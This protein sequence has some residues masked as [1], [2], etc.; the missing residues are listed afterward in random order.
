MGTANGELQNTLILF[1]TN[2]GTELRGSLL[3]LTRFLAVF[4]LYSPSVVLRSSEVL[5]NCRIIIHERTLYSG[6]AVIH[7]LVNAGLTLVC[8]ATLNESAWKDVQFAPE[9]ARNGELR[10]EFRGLITEWQKLYKVNSDY[11]VIIADMQTFLADL[12]LWL[13][14]V[15]LGIRSSPS[16]DRMKLEQ[17]V[18]DDLAEPIVPCV[19]DMFE[20]FEEIAARL[21]VEARPAHWAYMRRQLHPLVLCAPFAY[22]TFYKPLGFAGDYEM[23]NMIA[24]NGQEGGNLFAKL[25]NTWF[26]RQPP[27]VAHRN[28]IDYLEQKL[29]EETARVAG[30]G[31]EARMYSVACGPAQEVQRFVAANPLS[32]RASFTLLDFNEETLQHVQSTLHEF[33]LNHG[34]RTPLRFIRKSVHHI[35]KEAGRT[36]EGS[37]TEKYDFV[38]CAGLFDYLSDQVCRRLLDIMYGWLAPGGLLVGTNVEPSNPLRNGMEHLLDWHLIYR[39]GAEMRALAPRMAAPDDVRVQT[40][41]SG[42]NVFL[43]VRKPTHV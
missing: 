25:V 15:E 26:L 5:T 1:E 28:R 32:D 37:E 19:N 3:R 17:N 11:K 27:A 4:E 8:E 33:K 21:D 41:S 22:R 9:M 31:R 6:R 34:R 20:K 12:R 13:D 7:N 14:Q 24:R 35:L 2:Q 40:D 38:Y 39:T 36:I 42:V 10:S 30:T 18:A 43:E 16:A 29:I 23:V